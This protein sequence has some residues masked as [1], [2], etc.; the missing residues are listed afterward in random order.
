MSDQ[1]FVRRHRELRWLVPATLVG[2]AVVV[3]V[4]AFV[5]NHPDHDLPQTNATKLAASVE[6]ARETGYS[7]TVVTQVAVDI[8][9]ELRTA[10]A[11]LGRT[12]APALLL[13]GSHTLRF[14]YGGSTRQRIELVRPDSEYD[15][16][17]TGSDVWQWDSGTRVAVHTTITHA[18]IPWPLSLSTPSALTPTALARRMLAMVGSETTTTV[19]AGPDVADR[20]TYEM[21]LTPRDTQTRISEVHIQVDGSTDVP[22]GVQIFA[23]GRTSPSVSVAFTSVVMAQPDRDDFRFTPP[24]DATVQDVGLPTAQYAI[25]TN[26][27]SAGTGGAPVLVPTTEPTASTNSATTGSGWKA[28][29]TYATTRSAAKR[30]TTGPDWTSVSGPWGNGRLDQTPLIDTLVTRSGQVYVG[31]V[32]PS[33]LYSAAAGAR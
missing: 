29:A 1:S 6:A 9:L 17:R 27:N 31:A 32:E 4:T 28:V 10:V 3:A 12:P 13:D 7:G 11:S 5:V 23:R 2:V 26:R 20:S 25:D 14:W 16:F 21:D 18:E 30:A 33:V 22:L 8:P 15:L 19:T 24:D